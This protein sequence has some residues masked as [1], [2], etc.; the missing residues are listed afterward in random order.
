VYVNNRRVDA[1]GP[2]IGPGD[3]RGGRYVLLGLGRKR[4][5]LLRVEEPG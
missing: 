2:P 1:E 5:H 3:V 4:H